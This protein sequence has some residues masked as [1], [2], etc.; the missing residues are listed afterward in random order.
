MQ[1]P[2]RPHRSCQD[3]K[4]HLRSTA[5]GP[6]CPRGPP[7]SGAGAMRTSRA[8]GPALGLTDGPAAFGERGAGL[9]VMGKRNEQLPLEPFVFPRRINSQ[10]FLDVRLQ[11]GGGHVTFPG[12]AASFPEQRSRSSIWA[13]ERPPEEGRAHPGAPRGPHGF[14]QRQLRSCRRG[15]GLA[16]AQT[17]WQTGAVSAKALPAVGKTDQSLELVRARFLPL[18]VAF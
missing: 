10:T 4:V 17:W 12:T 9:Q 2:G 3:T 18:T 5:R 1:G 14:A 16:P 6:G 8:G 15:R 13:A 7:P 11:A